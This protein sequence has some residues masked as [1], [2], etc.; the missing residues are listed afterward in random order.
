MKLSYAEIVDLAFSG[1]CAAGISKK[2]SFETAQFLALAELDGLPSLMPGR[3][4]RRSGAHLSQ[5][6]R[7]RGRPNR[8]HRDQQ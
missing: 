7:G 3:H 4:A 5:S 1:L 6:P 2:T 8:G